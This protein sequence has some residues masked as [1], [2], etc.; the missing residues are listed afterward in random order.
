MEFVLTSDT[1]YSH[2]FHREIPQDE[3]EISLMK[4]LSGIN[5]C[6]ISL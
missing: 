2:T 5:I 6:R 3:G 1:K 4:F